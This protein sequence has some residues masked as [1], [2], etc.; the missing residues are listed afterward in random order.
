L[1]DALWHKDLLHPELSFVQTLALVV[2][3]VLATSDDSVPRGDGTA[4]YNAC[5]GHGSCK[6]YTC[7]CDVGYHGED[8]SISFGSDGQQA[9]GVLHAGHVNV[10]A[11]SHRSF[12]AKSQSGQVPLVVLGYSSRACARC[13]VFEAAYRNVSA[14]LKLQNV[15]W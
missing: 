5:S 9:V 12:V 10:T 15:S 11:K 13:V 8:C 1:K 4:C 6:L 2:L 3:R 14:A 7:Y